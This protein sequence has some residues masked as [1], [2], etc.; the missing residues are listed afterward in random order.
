M[1][2]TSATSCAEALFSGWVARFGVPSSLTSDRGTQFA[3]A[4][5]MSFC[6]RIGTRHVMTMA[7]HPQANGLVERSHRQLKDALRA[8]EAGVD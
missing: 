3:S 8:R 5:W 1:K 2:S 4:S 7:Y 6:S